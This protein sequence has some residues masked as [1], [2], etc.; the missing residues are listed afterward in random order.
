M[1]IERGALAHIEI[2]ALASRGP[3]A[4]PP[5]QVW[6]IASRGTNLADFSDELRAKTKKA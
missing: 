6:A 5:T 3:A 1:R 4:A 2:S